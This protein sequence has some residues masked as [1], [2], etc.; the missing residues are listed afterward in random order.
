MSIKN[1]ESMLKKSINFTCKFTY[2]Y[3]YMVNKSC[4]KV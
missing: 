4:C 2:K 3:S 1:E